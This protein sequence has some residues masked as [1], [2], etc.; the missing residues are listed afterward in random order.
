[1]I[2]AG[3]GCRSGVT[4][5]QVEA[6]IEAALK[7]TARVA[8][9]LIAVP[10]AKSGERAI[11]A[12]VTARGVPLASISQA[13]LEAADARTLTRSKHAQAAM[14]VHSVAEAAA[15]AGAGS[16]SELLG[17]RIVVGP[18]T[19]ALAAPAARRTAGTPPSNTASTAGAPNSAAAGPPQ[20]GLTR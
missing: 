18:V 10:A 7:Q 8:L 12:A 5:E 20:K 15:L 2:V 17:A 16:E 13:D 3:I 19:C 1:M 14:N 11:V 6:A 4:T 9:T